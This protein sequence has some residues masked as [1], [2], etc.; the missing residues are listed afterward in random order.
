MHVHQLRDQHFFSLWG[1]TFFIHVY[2]IARALL[3]LIEIILGKENQDFL[4]K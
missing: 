1:P 3:V 4:L 2:Y